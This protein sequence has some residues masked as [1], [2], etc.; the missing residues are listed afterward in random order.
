[1][2]QII[3]RL[4]KSHAI[5]L[6]LQHAL[7]DLKPWRP[8]YVHSM[9]GNCPPS[10]V[11][12]EGRAPVA[13][14]GFSSFELMILEVLC[15]P[16]EGLKDFPIFTGCSTVSSHGRARQLCLWMKLQILGQGFLVLLNRVNL[17]FSM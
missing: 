1:M 12:L 17:H 3:W 2:L 13:A 11:L 10:V 5:A 15:L 8:A 6:N 14:S 4:L 7:E 9:A 16:S